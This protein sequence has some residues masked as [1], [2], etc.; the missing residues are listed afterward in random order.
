MTGEL[1]GGLPADAAAAI[2]DALDAERLDTLDR[3]AALSREFD[4][5]VASSA[6]V[7]TDDEHDPEGATI[8]FERAQL[9]ALIDQA[10][11][12][13]AELDDALDRLRQ[14][15]YGRCERCGQPIA[16]ERLAA[17]PTARTCITCAAA[18]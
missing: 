5:I 18:R 16:A 12:H 2:R 13:L 4:G 11:S 1:P 8:A 17:R 9:A 15:S 3:I 6:G 7:A 10:R 14:G